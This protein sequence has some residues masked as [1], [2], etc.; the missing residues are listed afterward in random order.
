VLELPFGM[1]ED[2]E[3]PADAARRELLEVAA[4][5]SYRDGRA[6]GFNHDWTPSVNATDPHGVG[7]VEASG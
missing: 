1:I 7:H 5:L 6:R 2:G 4:N 3:T